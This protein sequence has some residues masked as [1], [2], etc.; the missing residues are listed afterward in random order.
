VEELLSKIDAKVNG[1]S[2]RLL[3][4]LRSVEALERIGTPAARQALQKV[5][6]TLPGDEIQDEVRAALQRLSRQPR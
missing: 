3:P 6:E 2:L 1:V 4:L 5:A